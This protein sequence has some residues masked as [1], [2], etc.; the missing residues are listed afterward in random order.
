MKEYTF[1]YICIYI[2]GKVQFVLFCRA[3]Q[4]PCTA[5]CGHSRFWDG[6]KPPPQTMSSLH[7]R[8]F[9]F[10]TGCMEFATRSSLNKRFFLQAIQRLT[11]VG[12]PSCTVTA[13]LWVLPEQGAQ[14]TPAMWKF[15]LGFAAPVRSVRPCGSS[16]R[17]SPALLQQLLLIVLGA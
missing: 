3:T 6:K 11:L 1:I 4:G 17:S 10:S 16:A 7:G 14:D 12:F 13:E 9:C 5:A 2:K 8:W 15:T